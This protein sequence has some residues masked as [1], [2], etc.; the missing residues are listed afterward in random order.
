MYINVTLQ[1]MML[2]LEDYVTNNYVFIYNSVNPN[3]DMFA[4]ANKR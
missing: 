4:L 2:S 3:L 1:V